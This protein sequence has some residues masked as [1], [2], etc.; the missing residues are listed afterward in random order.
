M[1]L[2]GVIPQKFMQSGEKY[3]RSV[4]E[5]TKAFSFSLTIYRVV[6]LLFL[7]R[8]VLTKPVPLVRTPYL[9][10]RLTRKVGLLLLDSLNLTRY[11]S[12][13]QH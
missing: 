11:P 1:V 7:A 12:N 4:G 10:V 5:S 13:R 2:L 6:F 8:L 9:L 3:V